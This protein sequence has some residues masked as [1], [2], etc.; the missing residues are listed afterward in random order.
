MKALYAVIAWSPVWEETRA[1]DI[2]V[3]PAKGSGRTSGG[4]AHGLTMTMG[5]VWVDW[6]KLSPKD[7]LLRLMLE[8][9]AVV[10]RDGIDPQRAHKAFLQIDEYAEHI[11]RDMP[12]ARDMP[13]DDPI[14]FD[15][16]ITNPGWS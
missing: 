12:G 6:K 13:E 14:Q 3:G 2:D 15:N 10:V 4:W 7:R 8:F 5:A 11:S 16:G 9:N 1:G